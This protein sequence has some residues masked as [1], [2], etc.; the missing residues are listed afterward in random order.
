MAAEDARER[1]AVVT[2]WGFIRALTG[3]PVTNGEIVRIEWPG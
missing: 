3:K 2:H 1:V